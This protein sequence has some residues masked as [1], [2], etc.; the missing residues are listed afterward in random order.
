WYWPA[1]LGFM[2]V[3]LGYCIVSTVSS[4]PWIFGMFEISKLMRGMA[5][6]LVAALYVRRERDLGVIALGLAVAILAESALA[7]RERLIL[8]MYRPTGT[9]FHPNSLSM[10]FCM[11]VPVLIAAACSNF[12]AWL[13]GICWT[14]ALA[15]ACTMLL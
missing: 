2:L 4:S 10:Y 15:G 7:A 5:F 9:L 1:S 14:A 12:P 8:G 11:A 6:F 3:Y 13:R